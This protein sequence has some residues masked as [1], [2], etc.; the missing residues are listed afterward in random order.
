MEEE[1]KEGGDSPPHGDKSVASVSEGQDPPVHLPPITMDQ[2][3]QDLQFPSSILMIGKKFSGKTNLLRNIIDKKKFNNVFVITLS[4]HTGNLTKLATDEENIIEGINDEIIDFMLEFQVNNPKSK[5]C[6]VF[7]DFIDSERTLRAVPKMMKLA[8]SGRNFNITLVI[9]SQTV[10]Q[11]PTAVRKNAEYLFIGKNMMSSAEQLGREYATGQ[12]GIKELKKQIM[13][14]TDHSWLLY[15]E[16]K[17]KWSKLPQ[18]EI[19]VF[20]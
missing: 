2:L 7:D 15:D 9:S 3:K 8:T 17:G 13:D 10:A 12:I 11:V 18:G 20:V 19:K 6:I 5:T 4:G 14:I 16:R 1:K